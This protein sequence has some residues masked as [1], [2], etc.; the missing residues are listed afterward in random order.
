VKDDMSADHS[1][2]SGHEPADAETFVARIGG[3]VHFIGLFWFVLFEVIQ[4]VQHGT[5][6][7]HRATLLNAVICLI[8][9]NG[10]VAA[11]GHLF[12]A[13]AT[14]SAIGWSDGGPFQWEVGMANLGIGVAGVIAA[15][16]DRDY[17]LAVILVAAIFLCGAAVGHV[18]DLIRHRNTAAG[19]AGPILYT[20]VL[21]PVFAL[22]LYA[23]S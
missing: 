1:T 17:W 8:G 12:F 13:K 2:V 6:G 7:L 10:I 14:A 9:I 20:D 23:T 3:F 22:V 11:S 5:D 16:Y 18:V 19:N 15:A 4:I 21:F